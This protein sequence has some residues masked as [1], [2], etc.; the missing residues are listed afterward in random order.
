[1]SRRLT[2]VLGLLAIVVAATVTGTVY[3]S[4]TTVAATAATTGT[5]ANPKTPP[6]SAV[7]GQH[8]AITI[9]VDPAPVTVRV[10]HPRSRDH[11]QRLHDPPGRCRAAVVG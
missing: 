3:A 2:L 5:G 4:N 7:P 6:A 9:A 10:A 11:A 8:H 1:M